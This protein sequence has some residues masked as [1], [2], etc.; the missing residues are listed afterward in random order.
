M[1]HLP[2]ARTE[3]IIVQDLRDELLIYNRT[4]DQAYSL[5]ETSKIVFNACDG[6]TSFDE[7]KRR[8]KYTDELIYLALDE[9]KKQNL[10]ETDYVSPFAGVSRREVIRQ[11]GLASMIALPVIA[12]VVAPTAASA[13]SNNCAPI[14]VANGQDFCVNCRGEINYITYG[15]TDNCTG[16]LIAFGRF[17]CTRPEPLTSGTSLQR[18]L[19]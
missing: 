3:N 10:I 2:K 7:L 1:N 12:N 9:L 15:S 4:T 5:N 17:N 11:V 14:C 18:Y 13:A 6:K 19:S 8:H 16:T